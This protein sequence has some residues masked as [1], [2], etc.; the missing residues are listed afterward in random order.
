MVVLFSVLGV[1]AYLF[2]FMVFGTAKSSIHEAVALLVILNGTVFIVGASIVHSIKNN[3]AKS[4]ESVKYGSDRKIEPS[5]AEDKGEA[6]L[7]D[8]NDIE[9]EGPSEC[10][11]KPKISQTGVNW[12]L[13]KE[14]KGKK[15]K[16]GFESTFNLCEICNQSNTGQMIGSRYVCNACK[17]SYL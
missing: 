6:L 13:V 7:K 5:L 9:S 15:L 12:E 4:T 8:N 1:L 11:D 2:G 16:L 10:L 17:D 3:S 14:L